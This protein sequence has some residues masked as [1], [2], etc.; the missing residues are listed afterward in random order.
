MA[1]NYLSVF[2]C[3][4][5]PSSYMEVGSTIC[6]LILILQVEC[7]STHTTVSLTQ[8]PFYRF[9]PDC[10]S[11]YHYFISTANGFCDYEMTNS[12]LYGS[13]SWAETEVSYNTSS[14]CDFGNIFQPDIFPAARRT[15]EQREYWGEPDFSQ[16]N[17]R[18]S[19]KRTLYQP[20]TQLSVMNVSYFH[21]PIYKGFY[22]YKLFRPPL[23]RQ[24]WLLKESSL[25]LGT[26]N[27]ARQRHYIH[28][29][30]HCLLQAHITPQV[31]RKIVHACCNVMNVQHPRKVLWPK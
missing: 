23:C 14:P 31:T 4:Q 2:C 7:F 18:E 24:L 30:F 12:E 27:L 10:M 8:I 5:L 21:K 6:P 3:R 28:S 13:N 25:E 11:H 19:K 15:C 20:F 26:S 16:C 29:I 22:I 9:L 17:A 1:C